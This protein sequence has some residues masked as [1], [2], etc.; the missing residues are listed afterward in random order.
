MFFFLPHTKRHTPNSTRFQ[1][2]PQILHIAQHFESMTKAI[3][4][5]RQIIEY[6]SNRIMIVQ[7][8]IC[9]IIEDRK[10]KYL[11]WSSKFQFKFQ[12]LHYS[13]FYAFHS[14]AEFNIVCAKAIIVFNCEFVGLF[15]DWKLYTTIGSFHNFYSNRI[16]QSDL[17]FSLTW[18]NVFLR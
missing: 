12:A 16:V 8:F 13:W 10:A 17:E 1:V 5:R 11:H 14:Y 6:L 15:N 9:Q 4:V 7:T 2:C 3:V 18:S